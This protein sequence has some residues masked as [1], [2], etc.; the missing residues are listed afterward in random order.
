[1]EIDMTPLKI[2]TLIAFIVSIVL[3]VISGEVM[4][5]AILWALWT[6]CVPAALGGLIP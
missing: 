2:L 4:T 5:N 1:M 3:G 6:L